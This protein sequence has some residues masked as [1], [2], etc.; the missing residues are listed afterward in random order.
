MLSTRS[1]ELSAEKTEENDGRRIFMV[2]SKIIKRT[3][4]AIA[5]A[6]VFFFNANIN[7]IDVFPDII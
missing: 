7:I 3:F 5:V 4:V 6:F 1:S 2:E